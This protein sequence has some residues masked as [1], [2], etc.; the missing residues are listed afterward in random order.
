MAYVIKYRTKSTGL[1]VPTATSP[2]MKT[3]AKTV[4]NTKKLYLVLKVGEIFKPPPTS[5]KDGYGITQ[6]PV[7]TD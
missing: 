4:A 3:A 7:V 6:Y 2:T 5:E 1:N